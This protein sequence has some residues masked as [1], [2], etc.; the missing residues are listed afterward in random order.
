[1]GRHGQVGLFV[2]NP[3]H[4]TKGRRFETASHLHL[5]FN[6]LSLVADWLREF[7]LAPEYLP[8]KSRE[9]DRVRGGLTPQL[10]RERR[11]KEKAGAATRRS[12]ER[13]MKL[14]EEGSRFDSIKIN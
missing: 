4:G 7:S 2:N 6:F 1:M 13:G 3:S 10:R 5:S 8:K 9:Q 11:Q 12:F 14:K